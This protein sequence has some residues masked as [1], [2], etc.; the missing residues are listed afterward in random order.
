MKRFGM[1]EPQQD[2][3]FASPLSR[4]TLVK[5]QP[6]MLAERRPWSM[7]LVGV[8][9][10]ATLGV[11]AGGLA[12]GTIGFVAVVVDNP[13]HRAIEP[14]GVVIFGAVLGAIQGAWM[15]AVIGGVIGLISG[16]MNPLRLAIPKRTS[17]VLAAIGGGVFGAFAGELVLGN[18]EA[19]LASAVLAA[20]V[21]FITGALLGRSIATIAIR[22]RGIVTTPADFAGFSDNPV[23]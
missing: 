9:Y 16:L 7:L 23:T 21:G 22:N 8:F 10:G 18:M 1:N 2:N 14:I 20:A 13:L 5:D 17:A 6:V 19:I 15:G 11:I 12:A 4:E 3:P